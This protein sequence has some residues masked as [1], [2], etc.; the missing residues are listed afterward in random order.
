MAACVGPL[1][2]IKEVNPV[3]DTTNEPEG[4]M[5][6]RRDFIY[7]ATGM[8][9][10]VGAVGIAWPFV[11]S[12]APDADVL[13]A[14]QPVELDISS[15]EPGGTITVN[16]R[17]LPYFV[18]HLTEDE[19]TAAEGLGEGDMKDFTPVP[20]RIGGPD[21][22]TTWAIVAANCTHLGCVPNI[23]DSAPEGWFCPCHGSVFDMTGRILR[24]P[25]ASNLPLP[26]YVFA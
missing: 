2:I 12:M 4:E 21:G 22:N 25:A 11:A 13:A 20:D 19:L 7:V 8:M 6:T 16:W 15:V 23:V 9:G 14:G 26:P 10:A 1:R 24:G 18:R 5:P 17:G 3:S